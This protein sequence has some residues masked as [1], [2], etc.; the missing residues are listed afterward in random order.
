MKKL[1]IENLSVYLKRS[2]KEK[3]LLKNIDFNIKEGEHI[4]IIGESGSG[5][6]LFISFILGL[7]ENSEWRI[8]GIAKMKGLTFSL[9]PQDSRNS[10]NPMMNIED[11]FFEILHNIK[12]KV[13]I[14]EKIVEVL[15]KMYIEDPERVLKC[16]PFQ[17]SGG[18]LQRVSIALAILIEPDILIADEPTTALDYITQNEI[19]FLLND[20]KKNRKT[21]IIVI[22]HD[23]KVM[24]KI[25]DK[26]YVMYKG[27]VVEESSLNNIVSSPKHPYTN[28]LL[29]SIPK[30]SKEK[31]K[32]LLEYG[33]RLDNKNKGCSFFSRCPIKKVICKYI[34]PEVI[35]IKNHGKIKCRCIK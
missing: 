12:S 18:M 4:G 7:L 32:K 15:K 11:H 1:E 14:R 24:E 22:S 5:K 10:F 26:V 35:D 27:E 23:F 25:V 34:S 6:T 9:V 21:S 31:G 8:N 20:L 2:D 19:L 33:N 30:F 28:L 29:S 13:E 16:Y 3:Q 17:L